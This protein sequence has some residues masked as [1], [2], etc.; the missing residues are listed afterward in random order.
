ML[1]DTPLVRNLENPR[2]MEILL[3]DYANLEELFAHIGSSTLKNIAID[4]SEPGPNLILPGFRKL[5]VIKD[6]PNRVL[7]LSSPPIAVNSN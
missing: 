6:L 1:A 3:K 5:I 4:M 7:R 2:Y